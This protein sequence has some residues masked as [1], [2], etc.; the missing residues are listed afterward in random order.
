M[1]IFLGL[2]DPHLIMIRILQSLCRWSG[3]PYPNYPKNMNLLKVMFPTLSKINIFVNIS[4]QEKAGSGGILSSLLTR[5]SDARTNINNQTNI[6]DKHSHKSLS[7]DQHKV[8]LK[9]YLN[10]EPCGNQCK[11]IK[12]VQNH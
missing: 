5:P 1:V 10:Q 6:N 8:L 7:L 2:K 11:R 12:Q 3:K 4:D 9:K